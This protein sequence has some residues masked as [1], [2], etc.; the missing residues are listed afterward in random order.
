MGSH[1]N[2]CSTPATPIQCG[3]CITVGVVTERDNNNKKGDF[4]RARPD[5]L[6]TY[7]PI[8]RER[9]CKQKKRGGINDGWMD[10]GLGPMHSA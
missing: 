3:L 9:D 8:E 6:P 7:N 2:H 4:L 5:D 1:M 10:Y